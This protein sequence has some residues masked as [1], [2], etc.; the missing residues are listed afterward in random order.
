MT[1]QT[2]LFPTRTAQ[3]QASLRTRREMNRPFSV[4][5][6]AL[7]RVY[8]LTRT[9]RWSCLTEL[10]SR[11]WCANLTRLICSMI[12]HSSCPPLRVQ[13]VR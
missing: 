12:H 2:S 1:S 8:S 7:G 5:R 3:R 6:A 4:D 11:R 10:G 13:S 9:R